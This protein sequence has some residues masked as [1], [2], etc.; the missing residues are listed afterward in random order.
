MRRSTHGHRRRTH[1]GGERPNKESD[2]ER[3][4]GT[5]VYEVG[6]VGARRFQGKISNA[7]HRRVRT[8]DVLVDVMGTTLQSML[9]GSSPEEEK[10]RAEREERWSRR[11]SGSRMGGGGRS[12]EERGGSRIGR[13]SIAP[14]QV[15]AENEGSR[16]SAPAGPPPGHGEADGYYQGHPLQQA[17]GSSGPASR[18]F[19]EGG[20]A[21]GSS[22]ARSTR[23]PS[24]AGSVQGPSQGGPAQGS[25]QAGPA[26]GPPQDVSQN[27][28][29]DPNR[30]PVRD[31]NRGSSQNRSRGQVPGPR[32]QQPS[33]IASP[34]GS[35]SLTQSKG[36][37]ARPSQQWPRPGGK[38]SERDSARSANAG[39]SSRNVAIPSTVYEDSDRGDK[40][41]ATSRRSSVLTNHNQRS[42]RS[43]RRSFNRVSEGDKSRNFDNSK[44][45]EDGHS[46]G[47]GVNMR[48]GGSDDFP[49]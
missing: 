5:T 22:Q 7:P 49:R 38:I 31:P 8:R 35:N 15:P 28:S 33:Q 13:R 41:E 14:E 40:S 34:P 6:E 32:P 10:A 16:P 21:R 37:N 19:S 44:H 1:R 17:Q 46:D 23:G 36:T 9:G 3:L 29:Q 48:G 45:D 42:Q 4:S 27:Y 26:R 43:G 47:N 20:P 2:R 12:D 18:G 39:R 24:Q 11:I 30:G 25:S